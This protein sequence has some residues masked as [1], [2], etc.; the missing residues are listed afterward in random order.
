MPGH[1]QTGDTNKTKARPER[2]RQDVSAEAPSGDTLHQHQNGARRG[3]SA[4]RQAE[5]GP[6]APVSFWLALRWM[7]TAFRR[8]PPGLYAKPSR[9]EWCS[10]LKAIHATCAWRVGRE[11]PEQAATAMQRPALDRRCGGDSAQQHATRQ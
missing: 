3:Y 6:E 9:V 1:G 8:A 11:G 2:A 5:G 7:C 10:D 4:A